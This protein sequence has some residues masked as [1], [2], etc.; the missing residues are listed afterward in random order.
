VAQVERRWQPQG[1][2]KDG[3]LEALKCGDTVV[4]AAAVRVVLALIQNRAVDPDILDSCGIG[5]PPPPSP[6]TPPPSSTPRRNS[7]HISNWNQQ[8]DKERIRGLRAQGFV[9]RSEAQGLC[10]SMWCPCHVKEEVP[11]LR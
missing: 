3:F 2:C 4:A 10:L 6:P 1:S 11:G 8:F 5:T 7:T 9:F